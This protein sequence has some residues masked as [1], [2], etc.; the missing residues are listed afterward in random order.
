MVLQHMTVCVEVWIDFLLSLWHAVDCWVS[1]LRRML[2]ATWQSSRTR[3]QP[4]YDFT[5][6]WFTTTHLP[7]C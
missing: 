7:V 2:S 6:I 5:R 3:T 4:Q 1:S